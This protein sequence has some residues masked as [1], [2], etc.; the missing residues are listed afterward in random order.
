MQALQSCGH[1]RVLDY[2][3][4]GPVNGDLT[5]DLKSILS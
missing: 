2:L 3:D 4:E 5:G 1:M